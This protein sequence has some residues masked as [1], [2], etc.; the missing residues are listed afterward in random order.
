MAALDLWEGTRL[1]FEDCLSVEHV[2]R[3]RLNGTSSDDRDFDRV[4]DLRRLEP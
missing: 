3:Q 1:D 2:R 4:R